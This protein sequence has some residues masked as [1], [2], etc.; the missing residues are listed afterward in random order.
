MVGLSLCTN[1]TLYVH[2]ALDQVVTF[3]W[4][5]HGVCGNGT[6]DNVLVPRHLDLTQCCLLHGSTGWQGEMGWPLF[7][8]YVC[9]ERVTTS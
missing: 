5:E 4:N 9:Q 3:G 7:C 2:T 8:S 6:Q 1:N